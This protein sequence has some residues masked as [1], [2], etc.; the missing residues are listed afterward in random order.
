MTTRKKD[1]II[2]KFDYNKENYILEYN[3][4]KKR[5]IFNIIKALLKRAN[6]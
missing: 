1:P 3:K 5:G 4:K 6:K 2:F